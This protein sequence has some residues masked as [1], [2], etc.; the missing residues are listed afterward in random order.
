MWPRREAAAM[1]EVAAI[2]RQYGVEIRRA[3]PGADAHDADI[4]LAVVLTDRSDMRV[5]DD[6][7]GSILF[8]DGSPEPR[9]IM[10][11]NSI[12]GVVSDATFLGLKASEWSF[13][14]RERIL[15][16]VLGRALAHEIGHYLLRSRVHAAGGLMRAR[17]AVSELVAT[18]RQPFGLSHD[19][20]DRLTAVAPVALRRATH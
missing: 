2:W 17:P 11:P 4:T 12:A 14:L 15:G 7:L 5:P 9:I 20:V 1:D 18:E 10:Y 19:E 16:R 8:F 3:R 6:V 13:D